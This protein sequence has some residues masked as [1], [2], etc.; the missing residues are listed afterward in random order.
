MWNES[1]ETE[2]QCQGEAVNH[3][4]YGTE[5]ELAIKEEYESLMKNGAWEPVNLP[6][7][8]NLVICKWNFKT[9]HNANGDMV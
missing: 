3:P 6:P 5:L 1:A 2:P 7:G 4:I 8:K 9:K